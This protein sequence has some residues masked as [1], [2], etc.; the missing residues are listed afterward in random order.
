MQ[1]SV[2][3]EV[4]LFTCFLLNMSSKQ[5]DTDVTAACQTNEESVSEVRKQPT[6]V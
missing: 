6:D 5:G 4:P 3:E 1:K 2:M